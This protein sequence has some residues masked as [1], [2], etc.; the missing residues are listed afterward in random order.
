MELANKKMSISELSAGLLKLLDSRGYSK[1]YHYWVS[2]ILH[3]LRDHCAANETRYYTWEVAED[4][5]KT[6]YGIPPGTVDIKH[7]FVHRVMG[8]LYDY[9]RFNDVVVRKRIYR[10]FPPCF[11]DRSEEYLNDL[12]NAWKSDITIEKHRLFLWRFAGFLV[13][14][15]IYSYDSITISLLTDFFNLLLCN[16]CSQS[17]RE[18]SSILRRYFSFLYENGYM[19]HNLATQIP[20]FPTIKTPRRLPSVWTEEEIENVLNAVD[21]SGPQGKRD[22]A[23]L[24]LAS[25]LGLRSVDIRNLEFNNIDWENHQINIVQKKTGEPLS[26]PLPPDVGWALIDYAKN[27][28]PVCD[29]NKIFVHA[30]APYIPLQTL[31]GMLSKYLKRAKIHKE[32]KVHRGMHAL[33]HSLA[34]HMLERETPIHVIQEVLGHISVNTTKIYTSVDTNKLRECALEVPT[35]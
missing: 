21:R 4:F 1:D 33:R 23:I 27:G 20:S 25:K 18:Y 34:T 15:G 32:R 11:K 16:H 9:Q 13:D 10:E 6:R 31:D 24:M 14:H 35:V 22:Y 28:R 2:S 12:H 7:R 3:Q 19:K 17:M 26:L 8:M 5:M 30:N 29:E